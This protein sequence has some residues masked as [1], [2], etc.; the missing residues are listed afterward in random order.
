MSSLTPLTLIL[1]NGDVLE[2]RQVLKQIEALEDHADV[3]ALIADLLGAALV[4]LVVAQLVTDEFT[5][6]A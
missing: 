2:H 6:D 5:V 1:A 4:E 3:R